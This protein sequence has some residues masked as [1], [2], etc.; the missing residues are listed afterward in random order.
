M[1]GKLKKGSFHIWGESYAETWWDITVGFFSD[2]GNMSETGETP[3]NTIILISLEKNYV[4][5]ETCAFM[6]IKFI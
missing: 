2:K 4:V 1:L 5:R 3:W 6:D